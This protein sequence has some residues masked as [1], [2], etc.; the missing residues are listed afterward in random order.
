[1][2]RK[3][4]ERGIGRQKWFYISLIRKLK[5]KLLYAGS[6]IFMR[7]IVFCFCFFGLSSFLFICPSQIRD[8]LKII[9]LTTYDQCKLIS[10][11]WA[12]MQH[13]NVFQNKINYCKRMQ[14]NATKR[15]MKGKSRRITPLPNILNSRLKKEI[16]QC[17]QRNVLLP[18]FYGFDLRLNLNYFCYLSESPVQYWNENHTCKSKINSG[19]FNS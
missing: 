11:H 13:A 18:L 6:D 4:I 10:V 15:F 19:S 8:K 1:M 12:Y 9:N 5:S 16:D 3:K 7:R 14:G 17:L 2:N